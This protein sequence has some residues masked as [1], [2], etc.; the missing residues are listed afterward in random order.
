MKEKRQLR[1]LDKLEEHNGRKSIGV[2]EKSE[3]LRN[4][5]SKIFHTLFVSKVKELEDNQQ[6]KKL[7]NG[8][9]D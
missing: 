7:E 8:I 9:K 3:G 5:H 1:F 2:E 4:P 6:R